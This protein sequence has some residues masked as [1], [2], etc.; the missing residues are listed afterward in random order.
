MT[1]ILIHATGFVA[2]ALNINGLVRSC[3]ARCAI[4]PAG[5]RRCGPSTTS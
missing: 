4:P 3:T 2:L 1:S 5:H